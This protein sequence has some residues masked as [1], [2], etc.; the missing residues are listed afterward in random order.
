MP[1]SWIPREIRRKYLKDHC[2]LGC[3][4]TKEILKA[5]GESLQLHHMDRNRK[6]N[7]P[8]NLVTT[9]SSCH[10]HWHWEHGKD[11]DIEDYLEREVDYYERNC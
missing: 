1:V 4:L 10:T 3:S 7:D 8:S 6:N 11:I 9:C 2:E 5:H